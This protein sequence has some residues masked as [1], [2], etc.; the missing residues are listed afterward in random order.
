MIKIVSIE[1]KDKGKRSFFCIDVTNFQSTGAFRCGPDTKKGGQPV[2]IDPQ[3]GGDLLSHY[4][5]Y[6]RRRRA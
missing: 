1:S 2:R 5:Q 3:D 6:H 4:T